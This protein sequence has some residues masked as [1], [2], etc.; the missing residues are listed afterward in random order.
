MF[1]PQIPFIRSGRLLG[2]LVTAL[3][4]ILSCSAPQPRPTGVAYEF[5]SAKDMFKRGRFDRAA[6]FADG[7]ATAVPP[8]AFTERA[9]VLEVAIYSGQVKAYKELADAYQKGADVTKNSRF[10]AEYERLRHDNLQIGS[11]LALALG[12]AAH[13]LTE[14][15]QIAKELTFEAPYPTTE[16]PLTLP[17][18]AHVMEGGWIEPDEQEAVARDA[19]FKGIDDALAGIVGGDRSKARSVLNAGPVKLDGVDFSLYLGKALLEGASL[20]DRKH[21]RDSLKLRTLCGVADEAAK[22]ALA[23]LK[24]NPNRDK[25]K[26]VKK[27]QDDVKKALK[28]L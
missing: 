24:E 10:K 19:Q 15:S 17:P 12:D 2:L 7:P 22:A 13:R 16:G 21:M 26:A 6:D 5:D 9:L 18:L 3:A 25:E 14:G 23:L 8:N 28:N 4:F 1:P 11:R 27:L 20:F